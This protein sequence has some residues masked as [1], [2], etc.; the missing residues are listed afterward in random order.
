MK[1]DLLDGTQLGKTPAARGANAVLLA[2]SRAG[3]SFLLYDAHNEAIRGF[4]TEYREA[5]GRFAEAFGDLDLSVRPFELVYAN[6]VVYLERDRERSLAFKMF[7]DGVRRVTLRR[8]V[9]WDELLR[10]LEILSIRF[11]GVRQQE[12]DLVTL[13][14]KAGFQHIDLEAIEGVTPDEED[15]EEEDREGR[16]QFGAPPDRD[17]PLPSGYAPRAAFYDD[18]QDERITALRAEADSRHLPEDATRLATLLLERVSDPL[19]PTSLAD[20]RFYLEELRDFLMSEEQLRLLVDYTRTVQDTL[21]HDARTLESFH[22]GFGRQGLRRIIRSIQKSHTSP[23][24]ELFEL[25]AT[26][27]G[28]HVEELVVLLA[29]ERDV[30]SRRVIRQLL[31]E[32]APG[33]EKWLM[34][35]VLASEPDIARDLLRVL[36]TASPDEVVTLAPELAKHSDPALLDEL[37]WQL[38]K[39]DRGASVDRVVVSMLDARSPTVLVRAAEVAAK[40]GYQPAFEFMHRRIG[41]DLPVDAAEAIG[42]AMARL[43]VRQAQ[44]SFRAWI[45]PGGLK[46]M[47][48]RAGSGPQAYA[49]LAGLEILADAVD[50]DVVEYLIKKGD[51]P[52]QSRARACLVRRRHLRGEG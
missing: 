17:L 46:S 12:D 9:T 29:T 40:R 10:L 15:E 5:H 39:L 20:V 51:K 16:E 14:W 3:R 7:R 28:E 2:L 41:S 4:L 38:D 1:G 23:P 49:A 21:G 42:V 44:A 27:P 36:G 13:L 11:T 35:Q 30:G 6:E 31:E 32:Y 8:D 33:R 22:R 47:L 45:R 25:L 52:L 48:G 26:V 34:E 43:D 18:V 50:D 24:S 37:L 19:D